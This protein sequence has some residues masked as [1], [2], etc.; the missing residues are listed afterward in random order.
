MFS[1]LPGSETRTQN[2]WGPGLRPSTGILNTRKY[3][4]SETG[5]V[6]ILR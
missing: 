4:V 5:S 1:T 6:S 3:N 2:Y